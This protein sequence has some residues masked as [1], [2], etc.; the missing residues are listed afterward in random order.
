MAQFNR[1]Y[2]MATRCIIPSSLEPEK[3]MARAGL[4]VVEAY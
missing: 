3:K 2:A 4:K 1:D